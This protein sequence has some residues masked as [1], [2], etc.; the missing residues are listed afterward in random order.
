MR[1]ICRVL[2]NNA[3]YLRYI[4]EYK[5]VTQSTQDKRRI[6][7]AMGDYQRQNVG[8]ERL[9]LSTNKNQNIRYERLT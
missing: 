8:Y 5:G 2:K 6:W 4:V 7:T 1:K 3:E 9:K